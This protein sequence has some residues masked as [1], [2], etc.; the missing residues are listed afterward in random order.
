MPTESFQKN[1]SVGLPFVL[2]DYTFVCVQRWDGILL[3]RDGLVILYF[4]IHFFHIV[5][6]IFRHFVVC[7]FN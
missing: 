3:P 6:G 4:V 1:Y 2:N 7:G 5:C